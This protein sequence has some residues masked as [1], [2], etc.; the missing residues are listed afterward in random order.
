V[1]TKILFYHVVITTT[2][3]WATLGQKPAMS[4]FIDCVFET[5]RTGESRRR[6]RNGSLLNAAQEIPA[7]EKSRVGQTNG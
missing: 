5:G 2:V 4:L 1:N 6:T 3:K 7:A